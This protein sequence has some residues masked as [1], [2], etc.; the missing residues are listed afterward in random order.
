MD[1]LKITFSQVDNIYYY[2]IGNVHSVLRHHKM[3]TDGL[4]GAKLHALITSTPD[5][6]RAVIAQSV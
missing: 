4:V 3:K 6:G 1:L 2:D 5:G